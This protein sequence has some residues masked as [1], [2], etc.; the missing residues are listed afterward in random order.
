M[1]KQVLALMDS[2]ETYAIR[3]MEHI[4]RKKITPFE[5]HAFTDPEKL[6]E[7]TGTHHV[8]ILLISEHDLEEGCVYPVSQVIVLTDHS[9]QTGLYPNVFKY[10]A[11]SQVM[12]E[13]MEVYG[14]RAEEV[15]PG[16]AAVLKPPMKTLGVFSPIA[17][18]RERCR[19][20][21]SCEVL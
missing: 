1:R 15:T 7:Y 19:N 2:E 13:V 16:A 14:R 12:R 8:E 17:L 5:V 20:G 9:G 11:S 10:Q 4:N 6:R 3:F 18:R 21:H